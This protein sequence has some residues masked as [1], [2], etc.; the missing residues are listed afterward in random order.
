MR[1]RM[2]QKEVSNTG[3]PSDASK[4]GLLPDRF[5]PGLFPREQPKTS[6]CCQPEAR[7]ASTAGDIFA[8]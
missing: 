3:G 8:C 1:V 5:E 4:E 6:P 7:S 2:N